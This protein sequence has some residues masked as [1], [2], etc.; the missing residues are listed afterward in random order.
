MEVKTQAEWKKEA[1][2]LCASLGLNLKFLGRR[3]GNKIIYAAFCGDEKVIYDG[4]ITD[5]VR[6]LRLRKVG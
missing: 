3:G 5:V 1:S 4:T 6:N 2:S